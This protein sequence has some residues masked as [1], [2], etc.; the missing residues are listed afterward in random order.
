VPPK[1]SVGAQTVG[2]HHIKIP[3]INGFKK[4]DGLRKGICCGSGLGIKIKQL[5]KMTAIA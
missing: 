3:Q 2:V 1:P 5:Y 4:F